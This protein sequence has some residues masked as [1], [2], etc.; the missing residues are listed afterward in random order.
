MYPGTRGAPRTRVHNIIP[1]RNRTQSQELR[2]IVT[3]SLNILFTPKKKI[4]VGVYTIILYTSTTI[5]VPGDVDGT[6]V[7]PE[8]HP[9]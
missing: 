2:G 8:N 3:K 9:L 5:H 7:S 6:D 1:F 4:K